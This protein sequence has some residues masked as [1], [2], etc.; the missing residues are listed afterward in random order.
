M[1]IGPV[2]EATLPPFSNQDGC[3]HCGRRGPIR[4]HFDRDC[5]RVGGEHFHRIGTCGHEWLERCSARP[6]APTP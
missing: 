6:L 4:V 2:D 1:P 3:P 5:A